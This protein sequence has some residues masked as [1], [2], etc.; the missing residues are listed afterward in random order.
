LSAAAARSALAVGRAVVAAAPPPLAARKACWH[1][2]E[3]YIAFSCR[4][5]I[6]AAPPVGTPAQFA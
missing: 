6:A 1:A 2:G 3:V 4:Q 5:D